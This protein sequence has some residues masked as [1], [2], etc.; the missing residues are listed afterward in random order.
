ML[1]HCCVEG[2]ESS[3]FNLGIWNWYDENKS[4]NEISK[5]CI[6]K[7]NETQE[8]LLMNGETFTECCISR[9][10]KFALAGYQTGY[11]N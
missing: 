6:K 10:A 7:S 3:L 8:I 1:C 11:I 5:M 4:L 2:E 9:C